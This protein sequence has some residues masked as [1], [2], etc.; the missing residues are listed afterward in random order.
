MTTTKKKRNLYALFETDKDLENKGVQF[1]FGDSQFLCKRAGGSNRQFDTVFQ[2]KTRAFQTGMQLASLS[3]E[4]SDAILME[5]YFEAVVIGWQDV[6]DREGNDLAFT[7]ENF[8]QVMKDLP[9]LW[10]G[11][12]KAAADLDSFLKLQAKEAAEKLGNS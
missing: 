8:V 5:V 10:R 4:Q 3:D 11:L 9:D 12:R 7:K 6:T 1:Q 2:E